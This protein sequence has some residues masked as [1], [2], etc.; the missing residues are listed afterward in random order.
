MDWHTTTLAEDSTADTIHA[1]VEIDSA[2]QWF[3][4]HFPNEP[5][6]PGFAILAMVFDAISLASKENVTL[7][8][9]KKIRFKQ[10]IKPGD[11]IEIIT[12]TH[13]DPGM[14]PFT[15]SAN[16]TQACKGAL[17]VDPIHKT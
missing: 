9:L 12:E 5:I 17:M 6:L 8:G 10:P 3:N 2:S 13:D 1:H 11:Q 16:G 14:V 7:K 4:G 15:V